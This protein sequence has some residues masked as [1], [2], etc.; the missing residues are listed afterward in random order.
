M[1]SD[2][3]TG[4]AAVGPVVLHCGA[5]HPLQLP[6]AL[7]DRVAARF[8]AAL[9]SPLP[10]GGTVAR[11]PGPVRVRP[12][13]SRPRR[14]RA[15]RV[16]AVQESSS[17]LS[18]ENGPTNLFDDNVDDADGAR[19]GDADSAGE[20]V[21]GGTS[22]GGGSGGEAGTDGSGGHSAAAAPAAAAAAGAAAR[23]AAAA[24]EPD[25]RAG[26]LAAVDRNADLMAVELMVVLSGGV[27][28]EGALSPIYRLAAVAGGA[29]VVVGE[30]E[31]AV[32]V[33]LTRS[34]GRLIYLCSCGG[35]SG[36]ESL[37][38]REW[39]SKSTNCRH[40]RALRSATSSLIFQFNEPSLD[41]LL[42]R[43]SV[44]DNSSTPA[45][46]ERQVFYATK[47]QKRRG[48]F[49][50]L[51]G[52]SWSAVSVRPRVGKK[53][54]KRGRV[55]RAACTRL[56]RHDHWLCKHAKAVNDW[57]EEFRLAAELAGG[58]RA[59]EL[60][61]DPDVVL[62]Q[63]I[64]K[65]RRLPVT[66]AA[67]VAA[68]AEA[69]ARFSDESRWRAA[70]N[71]LPCE[72]EINA[73]ERYD[74][75]ADQAADGGIPRLDSVL[76]EQTCFKC[77]AGY[78]AASVK[79]SG[80]VLH[81]L[82]GRISVRM[83]QWECTCGTVVFFDGAQHGLFAS[84]TQ[85][86][87]TRTL[88]DVVSQMV[89]S[90][91]STLSSASSVLCFLLEVTKALPAGRNSLSRQ[92]L[93]AVIHRF[94]RTLIVPPSLFRCR[95]CYSS[96]LR[97]YKVVVQ[98]GQVI[99]VMK[100]Q[101]EPLIKVTTD[102]STTRMDVDVGCSW[103]LAAAR[104]AVRKRS[105]APF[106]QPV[107][108]TKEEYKALS[109]LSMAGLLTPEDQILD[110]VRSHPTT[111][112]WACALI[113]FSF[114]K[115]SLSVRRPGDGG[116][117][118][119]NEADVDQSPLVAN[120]A[121]RVKQLQARVAARRGTVIYECLPLEGVIE[122]SD[123][124]CT[125]RDRLGVVRHFLHTFLAEPLVGAFAGLYRH[126]IIDLARQLILSL[127]TGEWLSAASAVEA[128]AIVWPFLWLVGKTDGADPLLL[129][130]IGELLLFT[131]GVDTLW[132]TRWRSLASP[133][134]LAF[135]ADWKATSV[136]KYNEWVA[137]QPS[138]GVPPSLLRA[139]RFST[140]RAAA[141]A[142]EVR[143]GHV[144]PDLDAVRPY[145]TDA[146]TDKVNADR[147]AK[148]AASPN[149]L[150]QELNRVL[151]A[152][153][154]RHAYVTSEIFMPGVE[155]F[156]CP[157]GLLVGF[158]FL[159]QAERPAHALATLVQRF[160]LLPNVVF[161]DTECQ[162]ARNAQRRLPWLLNTSRC[163]SFVDRLHNFGDQHK[164]SCVFDANK[165]PSLCRQHRSVCAES[166]HSL[167]KAFKTRLTH[168][169]QDHFIVQM[170]ILAAVI[171][172]RVMMRDA[173]GKETNHRL[174]SMFF[175]T[176]VFNHCERTACLCDNWMMQAAA[177]DAE[178]SDAGDGHGGGGDGGDGRGGNGGDT[179]TVSNDD[180][181]G[182]DTEGGGAGVALVG[183][184]GDEEEAEGDSDSGTVRAE[185]GMGAEEVR[186]GPPLPPGGAV[187]SVGER[188]ASEVS[189]SQSS[190]WESERE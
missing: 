94:S 110:N 75:L 59:P 106:D 93:T 161:F 89:F 62:A 37:E 173:L 19:G 3:D 10:F 49:A 125:T 68:Q 6:L 9:D 51:C 2:E 45:T 11:P 69:D 181:L 139:G 65:K 140:K 135:E 143:T 178:K 102:L 170:R 148:A 22:D 27:R 128:V 187:V 158:D 183:L 13:R 172:L 141:Q 190:V 80:G 56:S 154:C 70:R 156:L 167:N 123:D 149:A 160:P 72:R 91:H 134:S 138:A 132:E 186:S 103:P 31:R 36:A 101:S 4:D 121:A 137:R 166:R 54:A 17:E 90:G 133:A 73:C 129:R 177:A 115:V 168:L 34:R 28:T 57:C 24:D 136:T 63:P 118:A 14:S 109:D 130:A 52:G 50:V 144:F 66:D 104:S 15:R 16:P 47:T 152:D 33:W 23:Q 165:Y 78:R 116:G 32:V 41:G 12:P 162:L 40:A 182:R 30:G 44:L 58:P 42:Q 105:K 185:G 117:T 25:V 124:E 35:R 64:G 26:A 55:M 188:E 87:F 86:V 155:N 43:H 79:Y 180:G 114:F 98:D 29:A 38:V 8:A 179:D 113:F 147:A 46:S 60:V 119:G 88:V 112:R 107:R 111:V 67:R 150:E 126:A 39:M 96:P 176:R 83:H 74:R 81:T 189:D 85:T 97:P 77:G 184:N 5:G 48:I 163:H 84:T 92:T 108:L 100:H 174:M 61:Q 175:H 142:L 122:A 99:S 120:G 1:S 146:K 159:D 145:I 127:T 164:C 7:H 20:G 95:R 157:C 131:D 71:L 171:N 151:G 82:R 76:Y 53:S 169:R 18:S 21:G 153:D